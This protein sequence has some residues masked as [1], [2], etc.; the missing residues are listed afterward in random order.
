MY[1]LATG[2]HLFANEASRFR[3]PEKLASRGRTYRFQSSWEQ[4]DFHVN[5]SPLNPLLEWRFCLSDNQQKD[6]QDTAQ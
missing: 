1:S 3:F 6:F 2:G 4:Q 5:T